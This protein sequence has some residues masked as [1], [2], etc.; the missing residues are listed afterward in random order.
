MGVMELYCLASARY[1]YGCIIWSIARYLDLDIQLI[2]SSK[3]S[4][5]VQFYMLCFAMRLLHQGIILFSCQLHATR[6]Y[7]ASA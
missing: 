7:A 1:R 3:R 4:R 6:H 2:I 5:V